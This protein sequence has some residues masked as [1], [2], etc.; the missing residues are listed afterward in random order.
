MNLNRLASNRLSKLKRCLSSSDQ[1][2]P[3]T[4]HCWTTFR[5]LEY[6]SIW[7]CIEAW[8]GFYCTGFPITVSPWTPLSNDSLTTKQLWSSWRTKIGSSSE[9]FAL[10]SGTLAS[11]SMAQG[12]TLSSLS[13]KVTGH[14]CGKPLVTTRCSSSVTIAVLVL[15]VDYMGAG[16]P[17]IWETIFG[18]A[19]QWPLSASAMNAWPAQPIL[20]VSIWKYG[21]LSEITQNLLQLSDYIWKIYKI[22]NH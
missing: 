7:A 2:N 20:N 3:Q 19:V 16:S 11:H 14:N 13:R 15:E 21:G 6:V 8:S 1:K 18:G 22:I 17:S 9:A 12:R 10:R 4:L 5:F